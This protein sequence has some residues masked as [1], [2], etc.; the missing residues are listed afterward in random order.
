M[1]PFSPAG[2]SAPLAPFPTCS[3][4][5]VL[6]KRLRGCPRHVRPL[7]WCCYSTLALE[8]SPRVMSPPPSVSSHVGSEDS[9]FTVERLGIC[10]VGGSTR[11]TQHGLPRQASCVR[12]AFPLG[13]V[14]ASGTSGSTG[15]PT[16]YSYGIGLPRRKVPTDTPSRIFEN[17]LSLKA[18]PTPESASL[19]FS[20]MTGDKWCLLLLI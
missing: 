2:L 7:G 12:R 16:L 1:T 5:P 17:A 18:L 10:D 13:H 6:G 11:D 9:I 4:L 19:V 8:V 20:C 15:T 3:S 14:P